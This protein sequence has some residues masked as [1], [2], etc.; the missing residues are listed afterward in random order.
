MADQIKSFRGTAGTTFALVP[1]TQPPVGK[2]LVITEIRLTNRHASNDVVGTVA[3]GTSDASNSI[4]LQGL[5]KPAVA[6]TQGSLDNTCHTQ[7]ISGE[8]LYIKASVASA[9]D[10]YISAV[11]CDVEV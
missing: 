1:D 11:L 3:V 4:I 7:V 5:L 9:L 10:Y 2:Y 8:G 6:G